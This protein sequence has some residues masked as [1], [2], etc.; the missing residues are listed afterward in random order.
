MVDRP[1]ALGPQGSPEGMDDGLVGLSV[2]E[3]GISVV[4]DEV[5]RRNRGRLE[6]PTPGEGS[7]LSGPRSIHRQVEGLDAVCNGR[8]HP[9]G[10]IGHRCKLRL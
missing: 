9:A 5:D 4:V 10:V 7:D 1:D 2:L 8:G 6:A 3:F